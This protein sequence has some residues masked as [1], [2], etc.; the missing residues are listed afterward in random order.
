MSR[1]RD[2]ADLSSVSA[3]LDT[4]G[5]SEGAL[6][7]R[8]VVINGAMQVAQ[9]GTSSTGLGGGSGYFTVD[10]FR[11]AGN[12]STG[13]LTMSQ[14]AVTDLAGFANCVKFA[15]TT[16]DTSLGSGDFTSLN[17]KTEGQDLQRFKKGTS[18]AEKMTLSFYV[19]G[20]AAATYVVELYDA[21]NAR[22]ISQAFSVTD[23][24]NRV[25]L[26]FDGDTTGAFDDDANQSLNI[27]LYL[28][29]G[30][31]FTSGTLS[32]SWG[33]VTNANRAVGTT[34]FYDSTSRTLEFTG[35]QL[36]VGDT[37][38]DFEHRTYGD[39][40][41]RCQRYF[42]TLGGATTND[43]IAAG[44]TSTA[45]FFGYGHLNNT[46]RAAPTASV[47]GTNSDI[48]Y[49]HVAVAAA[50]N[51]APGFTTNLNSFFINIPSGTT[52]TS[53]AGSYAR[54]T[55]TSTKLHF[56]AEL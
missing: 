16:A 5:G 3:R 29:A 34:N 12:A 15:C 40:L 44:F 41:L 23:S 47:S 9:R 1:A 6:S 22:Q 36:E 2:I 43:V 52:T 8:N 37:A 11:I 4:V 38:T 53:N 55:S 35:L 31:D 17:F 21:D 42:Q 45:N 20:N 54:S 7:N 28:A 18:S 14:S 49:T 10:R 56:D 24:W 27:N 26:V 39:E 30:T 46:M 33:S 25:T 13:R 50:A 32:T 19:K 51:S 48:G